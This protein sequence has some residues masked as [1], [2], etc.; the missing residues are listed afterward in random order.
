LTEEDLEKITKEWSADLLV[1][2]DLAEMS[3]IDSPEAMPNTPGPSKTKKDDKVLEV[4]STS[5]KTTL[6]S[7]VQGGD[8][9]ELGGIEVEK[10][11]GEVTPPG[12]E[13]DP[14]K[15][16]YITPPNLSSRKKSKATQTTF[17]TTLTPNDFDFLIIA[18]NDASL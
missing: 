5:T 10:N 11:K 14:S 9:K 17:K 3:D 16:R 8:G 2:A 12:E 4:H 1:A 18:L 15:K 6:I 13:E 7:P